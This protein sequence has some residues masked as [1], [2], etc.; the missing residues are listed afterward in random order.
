MTCRC[1]ESASSTYAYRR[2]R[3]WT[4]FGQDSRSDCYLLRSFLT[5]RHSS[6]IFAVGAHPAANGPSTR[7]NRLTR[8]P[9]R[10]C[11]VPIHPEAL[12]HRQCRYQYRM[13]LCHRGQVLGSQEGLRVARHKSLDITY[14]IP[15]IRCIRAH[16]IHQRAS[17]QRDRRG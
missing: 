14:Q 12:W 15:A 6:F 10:A 2:S 3:D 1:H 5:W 8:R 9:K 17:I 13:R 4:L 7:P 11:I 16:F